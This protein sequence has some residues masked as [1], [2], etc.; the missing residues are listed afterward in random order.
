[1]RLFAHTFRFGLSFTLKVVCL[2]G[3]CRIVREVLLLCDFDFPA[4]ETW[5]LWLCEGLSASQLT[6]ALLCWRF[7]SAAGFTLAY[8][9]TSARIILIYHHCEASGKSDH[10]ICIQKISELSPDCFQAHAGGLAS[11]SPLTANCTFFTLVGS[12]FPKC[13]SGWRLISFLPSRQTLAS[14]AFSLRNQRA[15]LKPES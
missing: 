5:W 3:I 6:T 8:Q 1:M 2:W 9:T 4:A 7:H 14:G 11:W 15:E 13:P 12:I 10:C